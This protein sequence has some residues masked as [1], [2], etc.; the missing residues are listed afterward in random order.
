MS[1]TAYIHEVR[2]LPQKK[3]NKAG[4]NTKE[5]KYQEVCDVSLRGSLVLE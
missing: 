5:K 4:I 1:A 2:L 3:L